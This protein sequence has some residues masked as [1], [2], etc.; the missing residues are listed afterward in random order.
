[1]AVEILAVAVKAHRT[2]CARHFRRHQAFK[3]PVLNQ[4][5][6]EQLV[7]RANLSGEY[8]GGGGFVA[9]V[10]LADFF[11][12]FVQAQKPTPVI[13]MVFV[14]ALFHPADFAFE[15]PEFNVEA[16]VTRQQA[17]NITG[18]ACSVVSRLASL[19]CSRDNWAAISG[20]L[21]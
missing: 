14:Q 21:P 5:G 20:A 19:P 4:H 1:M 11:Q 7:F 9:L 12:Q 3:S 16:L 2:G 8:P 10:E 18:A 6:D 17:G 13:A 15:L